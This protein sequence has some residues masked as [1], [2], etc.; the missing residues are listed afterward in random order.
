MR[1]E[2]HIAREIGRRYR[3]AADPVRF[4]LGMT[5]GAVSA[6]WRANVRENPALEP[7]RDQFMRAV[8]HGVVLEEPAEVTCV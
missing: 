7:H 6:A 5:E 3:N 1:D 8:R 2:T 4:P